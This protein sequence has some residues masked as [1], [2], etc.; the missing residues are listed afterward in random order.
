M[1]N[2]ID[3]AIVEKKLKNGEYVGT[4]SFVSDIRNVF[5]KAFRYYPDN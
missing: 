1:T 4:F 3:L 2:Y 5:D